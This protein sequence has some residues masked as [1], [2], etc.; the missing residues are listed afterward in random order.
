MDRRDFFRKGAVAAAGTLAGA[1]IFSLIL[2]ATA[3]TPAPKVI[4]LQLYSLREA[5]GEDVLGTLQKV[6]N[7]GYKTLE[8]AGYNNGK[9]YGYTPTEFKKIVEDLGMSVSSAHC[10]RSWDPEKESEIMEWWETALDAHKASGCRYVIQPSFPIG[11][12]IEDIQTYVDYFNKVADL[13]ASKGLK[14]GFHN[15]AR[16]FEKRGDHVILD[17]MIQNS[18]D[19]MIFQLDVYWAVKGGVD[20]VDYINKYG[21]KIPILHIKDDSIIGDSGE[22]DFESIFNAA[23]KNDMENYYVEVE[24][25][26]LPPEICVE[27]SF[28]FLDV[29]TY[30]K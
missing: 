8:T 25:Y 21:K 12:Q 14:F 6:A 22:I 16:E 17:Y 5:M 19:N 2:G 26:T 27:R 30:V 24:R 23:Y 3:C 28:D 4:G 20:P 29:A 1:S 15:H 13:A 9:I 10:G 7:M 11:E 18:N